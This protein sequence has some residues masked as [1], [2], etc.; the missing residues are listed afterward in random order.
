MTR[1]PL[2][3]LCLFAALGFAAYANVLDTFFLSDDFAQIGKVLEGDLSVT[4]GREHGGFFRPAFILSY[5]V[6]AQLWGRRPL[7]FHLTNVLL[8]SLNAFLVFLLAARLTERGDAGETRAMPETTRRE[9]PDTTRQETPSNADAAARSGLSFI[10]APRRKLLAYAAGL[11]FLLHPSHTEAVTWISGRADLLSTLF[12]LL[13][14]LYLIEHART[15]RAA[16]LAFSSLFF[17]LALLSKEAALCFPVLA[18]LA[19]AYFK[20]EPEASPEPSARSSPLKRGALAALPFL[21]VLAAYVAVRAAALGTLVG[22]YGAGRHLYLTHGVVASQLLRAAMRLAFPAVALRALP[23][24]ESRAL[25]PTLIVAGALVVVAAAVALR[26]ADARR[27]LARFFRR[28]KLAWLLVALTVAAL[29]PA[30]NLRINVYDTQ[31]ERFLYLPSVFFSVLV[32][33]ALTN[34]ASRGVTWR[35]IALA[36][37]LPL[38]ALG[39]WTTNQ[40][41]REASA[42]SRRLVEDV[43]SQS[44]RGNVLILNAPD[45]LRGAYVFRNGFEQALRTFQDA[46]PFARVA[47][48]AAHDTHSRDDAVEFEEEAGV[49][50]VA[51]LD[52]KA[53]FG[54]AA[55]EVPCA[56]VV[57]ASARVVRLRLEDCAAEFDLFYFSSGRMRKAGRNQ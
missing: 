33:R 44:A 41:W 6:D 16:P 3:A 42:L 31:G 4:W 35:R 43:V 52:A 56:G 51:L 17:A 36:C 28:N 20:N 50:S 14:L 34:G 29:L 21:Y 53:S 37:L 19:G 15:R 8:H 26:R 27:A 54:Q 39:L 40:P 23:F 10:N 13:A 25:S 38:Y 1:A 5:F 49:L 30:L 11:I 57:E 55:A 22:G 45:N 9:T 48:V 7:G 32:A 47:V 24:L 2:F 12:C 46:K 18:A